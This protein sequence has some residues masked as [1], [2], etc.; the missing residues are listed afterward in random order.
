M[1]ESRYKIVVISIFLIAF[2]L[3][4][5][6]LFSVYF[7]QGKVNLEPWE[8]ETI[9]LNILN[10]R[11]FVYN[12]LGTVYR[13]YCEPLYVYFVVLIYMLFGVSHFALGIFQALISSLSCILLYFC[14]KK[15]FDKNTGMLAM[16]LMAIHPGLVIY[17]T[18]IHPLNIDILLIIAV[19]FVFLRLLSIDKIMLRDIVLTGL[20]AGLALLTRPTVFIFIVFAMFILSWKRILNTKN[21]VILLVVL[22]LTGSI[23]TIRNYVIYNELVFTRTGTGKVFWIGN[24]PAASGGAMQPDGKTVFS[25]APES[26]KQEIIGKDEIQQ[27]RL[28]KAKAFAFIKKHPMIFLNLFFKKVYYFFWFS[29]QTGILYSKTALLVYKLFYIPVAVF[30]LYSIYLVFQNGRILEV[31]LILPLFLIVSIAIAQSMFYIEGRHRWAIEP[32]IMIFTANGFLNFLKLKNKIMG[33][34]VCAH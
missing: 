14:A 5:A 18:K 4:L 7:K 9:A 17:T 16:L 30:A 25:S 28:F 33:G 1:R 31:K 2:V 34:L 11:G 22:S 27:N 26:F 10:G 21:T 12:D 29:P 15:M 32:I 6:P 8:Q 13:S 19:L 3:R 24:N 23:W 20:V